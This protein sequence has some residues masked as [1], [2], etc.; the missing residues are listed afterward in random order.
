MSV[1]RICCREV[2]VVEV[3]ETVEV[4][5][6]RMKERSVGTL[7][8]L[9]ASKEPIGILTD[10]DI[11]TRVV[12]ERKSPSERRVGQVMT[13]LPKTVEEDTPIETALALMRSGAF[14]RLPV[15]DRA[16]KLVGVVSL[17]DVLCLLSEEFS[18]I[19]KL[20][21]HAVPASMHKPRDT[22]R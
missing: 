8:V 10:R 2:N 20:I 22:P 3:T 17:D 7:V 13:P 4:A 6:Q 21:A 9:N 16:K 12:A 19:G 18:E 11:V 5:A 15:V 14:R 1:G